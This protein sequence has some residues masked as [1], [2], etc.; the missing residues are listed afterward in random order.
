MSS[1]HGRLLRVHFGFRLCLVV[2][3]DGLWE[4]GQ[5]AH[6][7]TVHDDGDGW[8]QCCDGQPR[9]GRF[10]A[11]GLLLWA[12]DAWR[13]PL[14]LMQH[15]APWTH[16][17]DLWGLPGGARHSEETPV[18]TA[19][20]EAAEE[21]AVDFDRLRVRGQV[22]GHP[23]G[24]TWSYTTVVADAAEPLP[25]RPNH[26]SAELAWVAQPQVTTLDLHPAF[27]AIW[28]ELQ[29][30]DIAAVVDAANVI[31]SR[32]DGW[33]RDRAGAT[34]RLL[35]TIAAA[36]PGVIALP[37]RGFGWVIRVVVVLEGVASRAPDIA[38]VE[39][40]RAPGSGD[41]TIVDV[42]RGAGDCVVVTADRGLRARLPSHAD[43]LSPST[44]LSWLNPHPAS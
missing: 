7:A 21:A 26:E 1:T 9:W 25:V 31:G 39:V 20:R 44:F 4:R 3:R 24:D 15:R 12:P 36:G 29:L 33:W 18:Q 11:A 6:E 43:P 19:L 14:V 40:V 23:A 10:G 41:D 5:V 17:G 34:E 35:H 13:R 2:E 16:C 28:P 37:Q 27:A 30:T 32:P 42:A 8:V 38:G 22:A